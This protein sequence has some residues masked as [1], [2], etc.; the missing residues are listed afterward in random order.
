MRKFEV[1][2]ATKNLM[3]LKPL[4]NEIILRDVF[5]AVGEDQAIQ[6][7]RWMDGNFWIVEH[8]TSGSDKLTNSAWNVIEEYERTQKLSDNY[9]PVIERVKFYAGL[10][11]VTALAYAAF[12]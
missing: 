12:H 8:Y 9:S 5:V 3:V 10:V 4:T 7:I 6:H 1:V 11:G 2:N